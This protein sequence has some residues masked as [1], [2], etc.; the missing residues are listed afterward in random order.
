[1]RGILT[2]TEKEKK[3]IC[4]RNMECDSISCRHRNPHDLSKIGDDWHCDQYGHCGTIEG[5][6]KC[7]PV[8]LDFFNEDEFKI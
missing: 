4:N 8:I 6:V 1:M 2:L 3:Y 5:K 7:V